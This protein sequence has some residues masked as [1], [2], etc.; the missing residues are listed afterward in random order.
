MVRVKLLKEKHW[1]NGNF[2][3][4]EDGDFIGKEYDAFVVTRTDDKGVKKVT[5]ALDMGDCVY[6]VDECQ[7]EVLSV[8]PTEE[9]KQNEIIPNKQQKILLVEDGS[10]DIDN[11]EE[12]CN[13]NDIKLIVY[14]SG[15][16]K[17][18]WLNL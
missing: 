16:N 2:T 11:L 4:K 3:Y 18:E 9:V 10:V 1:K 5:Y 14:R 13:E 8:E 7:V 15:A 6:F 17:P 12:W